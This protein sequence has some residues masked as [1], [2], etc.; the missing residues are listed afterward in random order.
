LEVCKFIF[1][2]SFFH[3]VTFWY[4]KLIYRKE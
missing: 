4:T 2:G 3:H 1:R